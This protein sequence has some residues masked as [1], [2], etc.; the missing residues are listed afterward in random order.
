[1]TEERKALTLEEI[2]AYREKL[3]DPAYIAKAINSTVYD[4]LPG[5]IDKK[6][7]EG[8]E[9]MKLKIDTELRDLIP[10]ISESEFDLLEKDIIENG[11]KEPITIWQGYIADGHHRYKIATKHGLD[12][13]TRELHLATKSDVKE[14]MVTNQLCRRNLSA[15]QRAKIVCNLFTLMKVERGKIDDTLKKLSSQYQ[16]SLSSIRSARIILESKDKAVLSAVEKGDLSIQDAEA[17]VNKKSASNKLKNAKDVKRVMQGVSA[18]KEEILKKMGKT[19]PVM[20]DDNVIDYLK[21][22]TAENYNLILVDM[23]AL[24]SV[25]L[26]KLCNAI[27]TQTSPQSD[28]FFMF[29]TKKA[30]RFEKIIENM[31]AVNSVIIWD[32][33]NPLKTESNCYN[34]YS[35]IIYASASISKSKK[36]YENLISTENK[37]DLIMKLISISLDTDTKVLIPYENDGVAMSVCVN[38]NVPSLVFKDAPEE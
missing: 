29:E 15:F 27:K 18:G 2:N 4:A 20:I 16:I 37:Y 6:V 21:K 28:I 1:M 24:T 33:V 7:L 5:G 22:N 13:Q 14:W 31:F 25:S 10:P 32:F 11:I 8:E 17:I 12:F 34:R 3:N 19:A 23:P 9:K 30:K 35:V 36:P 38:E 26:Q